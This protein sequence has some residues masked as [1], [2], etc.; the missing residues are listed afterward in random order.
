VRERELSVEITKLMKIASTR[1]D[2]DPDKDHAIDYDAAVI[3]RFLPVMAGDEDGTVLG[4]LSDEERP[5]GTSVFGCEA[6]LTFIFSV[7]EWPFV[8]LC[9]LLCT[10][11]AHPLTVDGCT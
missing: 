4:E 9:A 10:S 1:H 3:L 5:V 6:L 7:W 8:G 2:G 11:G